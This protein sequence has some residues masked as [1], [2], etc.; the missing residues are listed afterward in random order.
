MIVKYEPHLAVDT[1]IMKE[2]RMESF[3]H[4]TA[5]VTLLGAFLP[6]KYYL[7]PVTVVYSICFWVAPCHL[8]EHDFKL[9]M[10]IF[11]FS[12]YVGLNLTIAFMI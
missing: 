11:K 8:T 9:L 1:N 4:F 12:A 10:D 5:F 3:F 2:F 7:F 6:I